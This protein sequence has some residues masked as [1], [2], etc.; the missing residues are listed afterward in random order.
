VLS[1]DLRVEA[2]RITNPRFSS[3]L[4]PGIGDIPKRIDCVLVE[5]PDPRGPW[6]ARGMAEMPLIPLAPAV[7]AALHDATGV[8]FNRFPLTPSKVVEGL[9]RAGVGG[10]GA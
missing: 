8:W 7:T 2:G 9:R 1:E 6:G 10:L 3:Y 4:I 5:H